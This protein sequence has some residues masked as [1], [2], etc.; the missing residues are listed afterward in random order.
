MVLKSYLPTAARYGGGGYNDIAPTI[1]KHWTR[2][3]DITIPDAIETLVAGYTSILDGFCVDSIKKLNLKD[4]PIEF[5]ADSKK[6]TY[7]HASDM[8][9]IFVPLQ[10]KIDVSKNNGLYELDFQI[11]RLTMQGIKIGLVA[12]YDKLYGNAKKRAPYHLEGGY[13]GIFKEDNNVLCWDALT[14]HMILNQDEWQ[15]TFDGDILIKPNDT[16]TMTVDTKH[17]LMHLALYDSTR[18]CPIFAACHSPSASIAM[19]N[20]RNLLRHACLCF[21]IEIVW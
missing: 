3:S 8:R 18:K 11:Q 4:M 6:V 12:N 21:F 2:K 5:S 19:I 17:K 15:R 13:I 16:V 10:M 20:S 9:E 14:K 1:T 7:V